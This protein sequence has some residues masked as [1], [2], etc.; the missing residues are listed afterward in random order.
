MGR[1]WTGGLPRNQNQELHPRW[2]VLCPFKETEPGFPLSRLSLGGFTPGKKFGPE[3]GQIVHP[4][5]AE[6]VSNG[7]A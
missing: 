2:H 6:W 1:L 3:P 7:Q 4:S 5:Q